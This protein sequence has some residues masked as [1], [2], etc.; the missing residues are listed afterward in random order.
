MVQIVEAARLKA[1]THRL[2][3]VIGLV[4]VGLALWYNVTLPIGESDNEASHYRYIQYIKTYRDLPPAFYQW[5]APPSTDQCQSPSS[6]D[7]QDPEHQFRQ[8]PLYYLLTSVAF[9]WLDTSDPWWPPTNH[10]SIHSN[11]PDGGYNVAI[12]TERE[13]FPYQGT[14]LAVRLI[15][16]LSSLFGLLGLIAV[17]LTGRLIFQPGPSP[18][19]A[20][21]MAV[22]GF[23]P[24]YT[25]AASVINNDILVGALGL[26]CIYFCAL[27]VRSGCASAPLP[28]RLSAWRWLFSPS[29]TAS[30][31]CPSSR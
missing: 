29:T 28:W 14:T 17:Y 19:P 9:F 3:V 7:V 18:L 20:L 22:V 1:R 2:A 10:Y 30:F 27:S 6:T 4:F 25:F 13:A 11:H 5:P 21:M 15:R 8:P 23:V 26:W 31:C 24:T 12:H 16:V